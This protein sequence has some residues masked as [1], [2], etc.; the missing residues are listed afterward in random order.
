MQNSKQSYN[1]TFL[2]EAETSCPPLY[3]SYCLKRWKWMD[4]IK[5][6]VSYSK[7][8]KVSWYTYCYYLNIRT[9][10]SY[11][12]LFLSKRDMMQWSNNQAVQQEAALLVKCNV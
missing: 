10:N 11:R 12:S 9:K 7:A 6:E 3:L 8:D 4:E 5:E 2:K 1:S